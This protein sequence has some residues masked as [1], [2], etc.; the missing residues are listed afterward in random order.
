MKTATKCK[1]CKAKFGDKAPVLVNLKAFCDYSCA[2]KFGKDAA[3]KQKDREFKELKKRVK[4]EKLSTRKE[5]TKRA[6]HEYVRERDKDRLCPCC[7][8]PLGEGYQAGHYIPSGQNPLVRYDERNIHGQRLD[9]NYFAG[10]DSGGYRQELIVRIGETD[11][12]DI[13][14]KRGGEVKWTADL[15]RQIEQYYKDKLK[16]LKAGENVEY[17]SLPFEL[18]IINKRRL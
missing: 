11:L 4:G 7:N 13:E 6:C 2:A 8:K 16:R 1:H 14:S 5:A 10:G 18:P 3:K 12:L 15:L 17:E 9:C